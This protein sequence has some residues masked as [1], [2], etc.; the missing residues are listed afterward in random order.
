VDFK[1]ILKNR[2]AEL[3]LTLDEVARYV[4]VSGATVSRWEH[5]DIENIRRDKIAKLA[6]VLQVTPTYLMGWPESNAEQRNSNSGSAGL[7]DA[8]GWYP[9]LM[10]WEKINADRRLFMHYFLQYWNMPV[11]RIEKSWNI[12]IEHPETASDNA[13][14]SFVQDTVK[15]VRCYRNDSAIEWDIILNPSFQVSKNLPKSEY[16][17]A[18][19]NHEEDMLLLARHMEPIPEEDRNALKAQFKN[20]I[21]LYLKARGI[22]NTE[23]Q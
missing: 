18:Q 21:D 9:P 8:D 23:D 20:S 3:G 11:E 15:A 6:E 5:G 19:N 4:G 2:R 7:S 14:R 17:F 13:F 1:S 12:S 22:H 10:F 16:D